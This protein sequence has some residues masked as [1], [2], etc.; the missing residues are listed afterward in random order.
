MNKF[1][2]AI[3]YADTYWNKLESSFLRLHLRRAGILIKRLG[4]LSITLSTRNVEN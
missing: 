4:G 2:F 1:F 3:T